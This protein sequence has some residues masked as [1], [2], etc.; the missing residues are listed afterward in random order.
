[1]ISQ[2][3]LG[4]LCDLLASGIVS[5]PA[6]R[7]GFLEELDVAARCSRLIDLA[8]KRGPARPHWPPSPSAN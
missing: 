5:D 7:Q 4:A 2:V 3:P 8:R 6:A 1:M